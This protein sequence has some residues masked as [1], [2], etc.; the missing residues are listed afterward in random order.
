VHPAPEPAGREQGEEALDLV[1]RPF[2][3][4]ARAGER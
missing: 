2:E 4:L 1:Q 3:K